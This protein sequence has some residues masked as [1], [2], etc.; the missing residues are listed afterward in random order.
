MA[1]IDLNHPFFKPLWIRIVLT[2][3]CFAW[4]IFEFVSDNLLWA[5]IFAT[6]AAICFQGFFMDFKPRD[7]KNENSEG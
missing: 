4:A 1:L 3:A 5:A 7:D 6:F 2:V